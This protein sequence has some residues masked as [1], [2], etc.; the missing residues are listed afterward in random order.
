VDQ[1]LVASLPAIGFAIA[2]HGCVYR[3]RCLG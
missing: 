3:L 2:C 1:R